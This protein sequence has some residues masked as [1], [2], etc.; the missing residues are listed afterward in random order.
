MPYLSEEL[1]GRIQNLLKVH[2]IDVRIVN[3]TP[4]TIKQYASQ[5]QKNLVTCT[6][7]KSP[8]KI[9]KCTS[10]YVVYEGVYE[11]CNSSFVGSTGRQVHTRC[12]EHLRAAMKHDLTSAFGQHYHV[13]HPQHSSNITFN[14]LQ[15][16]AR[17]KLLVRISKAYWMR[18]LQPRINRKMEDMGTGFLP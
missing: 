3:P 2:K 13:Q 8:M 10:C 7:H 14:I 4:L 5:K 11:L 15:Y 9:A 6:T 17:E 16:T 18:R 1:N 12:Q